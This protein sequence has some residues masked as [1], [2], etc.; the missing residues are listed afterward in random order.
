MR[1]IPECL[2]CVHNEALYKSIF[3]FTFTFLTVGEISKKSTETQTDTILHILFEF[4]V[5]CAHFH[6]EEAT[7]NFGEKVEE[8]RKRKKEW[9]IRS[10]HMVSASTITSNSKQ[11]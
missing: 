8:K 6:G 2:K 9:S 10:N 7:A 1:A 5:S 4:Q 3:T 11:K